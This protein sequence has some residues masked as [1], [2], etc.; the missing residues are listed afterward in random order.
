MNQQELSEEGNS[1]FH[2]SKKSKNIFLYTIT[3]IV[4]AFIF[5]M[6]PLANYPIIG[7]LGKLAVVLILLYALVE[8][9]KNTLYLTKTSNVSLFEG[10]WDIFKTNVFSNYLFS[11]F[12]IILLFSV[13]RKFF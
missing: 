5:I 7:F 11:F 6:S 2:Y 13:I 1:L 3:S 8:N 4:L 12:M 10:N 9:I